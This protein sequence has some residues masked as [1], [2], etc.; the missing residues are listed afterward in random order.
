MKPTKKKERDR[1]NEETFI[2]ANSVP[3]H[4]LPLQD[5]NKEWALKRTNPDKESS[6]IK[7]LKTLRTKC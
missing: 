1:V 5:L 7:T 2:Y 6:T 3:L 4:C